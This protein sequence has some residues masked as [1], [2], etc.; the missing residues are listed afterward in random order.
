MIDSVIYSW[1]LANWKVR[2]NDRV[3]IWTHCQNAIQY[4]QFVSFSH[5]PSFNISSI[6]FNNIYKYRCYFFQFIVMLYC[7]QFT[8]L[9]INIVKSCCA[10]TN[11][12]PTFCQLFALRLDTGF[13][14]SRLAERN[15][16]VSLSLLTTVHRWFSSNLLVLYDGVVTCWADC[17][18]FL[19]WA[20]V[21][22]IRSIQ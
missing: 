15:N 20:Q 9:I 1:T 18:E 3:M 6:P 12:L 7:L 17:V 14:I 22:S 5:P 13:V 11:F 21:S 4:Q 19:I 16:V 10:T 8:V 2:A